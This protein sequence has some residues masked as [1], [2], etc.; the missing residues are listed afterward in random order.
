[1]RCLI[2]L[3]ICSISFLGNAQDSLFFKDNS[4]LATEIIKIDSAGGLVIYQ[5]GTQT[6]YRAI[7]SFDK[8]I[9]QGQ[10]INLDYW[11]NTE[12]TKSKELTNER[13]RK[14]NPFNYGPLSIGT[15]LTSF[16]GGAVRSSSAFFYDNSNFS[17]EPEYRIHERV[18]IKF[19]IYIG[20]QADKNTTPLLLS[21]S[22]NTWNYIVQF[23]ANEA[24]LSLP[25]IQNRA[26][27][28]F[29]NVD[30]EHSR[31]LEFQFGIAP[32]FYLTQQ[33]RVMPY[34]GQSFNIGFVNLKVTDYFMT[35]SV[36]K[37][38]P[39]DVY[40]H[41]FRYE[42]QLTSNSQ[43]TVFKYEGMFG[44]DFNLT[45]GLNFSTEVGYSNL[46]RAVNTTPDR[47]YVRAYETDDYVLAKTSYYSAQERYRYGIRGKYFARIF[48]VYRFGVITNTL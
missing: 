31:D 12:K 26:E 41:T 16:L 22:F 3:F 32:K 34:I 27:I 5:Y 10:E 42:N 14:S 46:N 30:R 1:M 25:E 21:K 35:F 38:N 36:E 2:I 9:Y 29:G 13:L 19:P 11:S 15:N 23:N 33:R 18:T 39:G 40:F 4:I 6:A 44:L 24:D 28:Y 43:T 7:K 45:K 48:L 17:I 8:I 20:I 47:V 37:N